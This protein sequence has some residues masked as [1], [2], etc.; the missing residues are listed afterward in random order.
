MEDLELFKAQLKEEIKA[1]ILKDQEEARLKLGF[2][3][4]NP[5]FTT[6]V[7]TMLASYVLYGLK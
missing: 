2:M 5:M 6:F 3:E 4:R 1:E 7:A